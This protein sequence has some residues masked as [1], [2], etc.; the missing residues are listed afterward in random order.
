MISSNMRASYVTSPMRTIPI[1]LY[2]LERDG[3]NRPTLSRFRAA[4]FHDV[5]PGTVKQQVERRFRELIASDPDLPRVV[6]IAPSMGEAPGE[7]IAAELVFPPPTRSSSKQRKQ[8]R[9]L[10]W[11]VD[12]ATGVV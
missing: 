3:G 12:P 11:L 8:A 7:I 1:H 9:E 4:S 10:I 5:T 2:H 6:V